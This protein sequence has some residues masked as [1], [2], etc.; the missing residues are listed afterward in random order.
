MAKASR[1]GAWR[2]WLSE[3][4]VK[5]GVLI[6][7]SGAL[8]WVRSNLAAY[9]MS[10]HLYLEGHLS[11]GLIVPDLSRLEA[12][13][14]T[15]QAPLPTPSAVTPTPPI[16][17]EADSP[18]PE[19]N[20]TSPAPSLQPPE[21]TPPP[22]P[23][24]P[25]P[26]S[27]VVRI[28]I[29]ALGISRAVVPVGFRSDGRGRLEWDADALFAT[30]NRP[31]LVGQP[32]GSPNPGQGGNIILIGHNYNRVDL[33]WEGV[34]VNLKRLR[35]G[36]LIILHTEDGRKFTYEVQQVKQVA[37]RSQSAAELEK[38]FRFL[39]PAVS[40]RL[41]LVTCGGANIWPFPARVYVVALPRP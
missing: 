16:G 10:H 3:A 38:H 9:Q 40:E 29:P 15:A 34:F 20:G 33:G 36:D 17:D 26:S 24:R 32:I 27:P 8:L 14:L 21:E 35:K 6:L 22:K 19:E 13:L 7:L 39:G 30:G 41:T 4:L 1:R 25:P 23:Q 5:G 11:A 12:L 31:D 2:Y 28:V 37:W 18:T